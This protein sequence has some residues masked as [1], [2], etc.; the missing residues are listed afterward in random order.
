MASDNPP[1]PNS[2]FFCLW[3]TNSTVHR[4]YDEVRRAPHQRPLEAALI[5][6]EFMLTCDNTM[7]RNN[8]RAHWDGIKAVQ[9][10]FAYSDYCYVFFGSA[11]GEESKETFGGSFRYLDEVVDPAGSSDLYC[12]VDRE[13][14]APASSAEVFHDLLV[15]DEDGT[16]ERLC[17]TGY[18]V[19]QQA[20]SFGAAGRLPEQLTPAEC[21]AAAGAAGAEPGAASTDSQKGWAV[22]LSALMAP[23]TFGTAPAKA[24]A[25]AK[26]SVPPPRNWAH[27]KDW[28]YLFDGDGSDETFA[29]N[30]LEAN[31]DGLE[32]AGFW[33]MPPPVEPANPDYV[34]RFDGECKGQGV[35]DYRVFQGCH[36]S[37]PQHVKSDD[38]PGT[39]REEHI[40]ECAKACSQLD[41]DG[42]LDGLRSTGWTLR[43]F[44]LIPSTGR[45]W[46]TETDALTCD[47]VSKE[48][49][50]HAG[51]DQA[52]TI[53]D[54]GLGYERFDYVSLPVAPHPTCR[55]T[56]E[57]GLAGTATPSRQCIFPF[58][59]DGKL[60]HGCTEYNNNGIAWCGTTSDVDIEPDG[61]GNCDVKN[62]QVGDDDDDHGSG[63]MECPF[64]TTHT[65]AP[66][67]SS[68]T[69]TTSTT[70]TAEPWSGFGSGSGMISDDKHLRKVCKEVSTTVETF[71]EMSLDFKGFKGWDTSGD[72]WFGSSDLEF[73]DDDGE[74]MVGVQFLPIDIPQNARV[75]SAHISFVDDG[76]WGNQ[77][78]AAKIWA[79]HATKPALFDDDVSFDLTREGRDRT[80]GLP[81]G[82]KIWHLETAQNLPTDSAVARSDPT[83]CLYG[84]AS[85]GVG[86]CWANSA[87]NMCP[88]DPHAAHDAVL[89]SGPAGDN[90]R[91]HSKFLELMRTNEFGCFGAGE[92]F[93]LATGPVVAN[94]P[95]F[96]K[97]ESCNS[98]DAP[99]VAIQKEVYLPLA[100]SGL[101]ELDRP[102][103]VGG[104]RYIIV[105]IDAEPTCSSLSGAALIYFNADSDV[106]LSA[107]NDAWQIVAG[108]EAEPA[109]ELT[110]A[111]ACPSGAYYYRFP[112]ETSDS[113][114]ACTVAGWGGE[115]WS[116]SKDECIMDEVKVNANGMVCLRP[117][118]SFACDAAGYL[119]STNCAADVAFLDS[120]RSA[121]LKCVEGSPKDGY[122]YSGYTT[123]SD[124][125]L[126]STSSKEGCTMDASSMERLVGNNITVG[127][128]TSTFNPSLIGEMIMLAHTF[129]LGGT[130]DSGSRPSSDGCNSYVRY[131]NEY[132][133]GC[134]THATLAPTPTPKFTPPPPPTTP[135][136]GS[137]VR[138][139]VALPDWNAADNRPTFFFKR[140][141]GMGKR[142]FLSEKSTTVLTAN[143]CTLEEHHACRVEAVNSRSDDGVPCVFPFTYKGQTYS[144]CTD[145]ENDGVPWCATTNKFA[146]E[147][148][149]G[150]CAE[151]CPIQESKPH[152]TC[153]TSDPI[154]PPHDQRNCPH[155]EAHWETC[156]GDSAYHECTDREAAYNAVMDGNSGDAE[157]MY[158]KYAELMHTHQFGCY[159]IDSEPALAGTQCV[160]PFVYQNVTYNG[161][162]KANKEGVL[163]PFPF[164]VEKAKPAWC[165]TVTNY[166]ENA[167]YD[168]PSW[169]YCD[170]AHYYNK[171]C[172]IKDEPECTYFVEEC[173]DDSGGAP[174]SPYWGYVY[175]P[176]STGK[177]R[178]FV[179][180]SSHEENDDWQNDV[181]TAVSFSSFAECESSRAKHSCRVNGPTDV[182]CNYGKEQGGSENE[183]CPIHNGGWDWHCTCCAALLFD[184]LSFVVNPIIDIF[185]LLLPFFFFFFWLFFC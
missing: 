91:M 168:V 35:E 38:N 25:P 100:K 68:S 49:H 90:E 50:V 108:P 78:L 59:Y 152:Q 53:G 166:D 162:T 177:P 30:W 101:F 110:Y 150:V 179:S 103:F 113:S 96:P 164:T 105:A 69:S 82:K 12:M 57:V 158:A 36:Y 70:S 71:S 56:D 126:D 81:G 141:A 65:T 14:F 154:L 159:S 121:K 109:A 148:H 173:F 75:V 143:V 155:G 125:T 43:G 86:T 142:R 37:E 63:S 16:F 21:A 52:C 175:S 130:E 28:C 26:G 172:S 42:T 120:T 99:F 133:G 178:N 73:F 32:S 119:K 131:V 128:G 169:G 7:T 83:N 24:P 87:F 160:F 66:P 33:C 88:G 181:D 84:D 182:A 171:D 111:R 102:I 34:K 145:V 9:K 97:D 180:T 17:P 184:A 62:Q 170:M 176:Q 185:L 151:D 140:H 72:M 20:P 44:V 156:W 64:D 104:V 116:E 138:H 29:A 5:Y 98:N 27:R 127:C 139:L 13:S 89:A 41:A 153:V 74:Q 46:C 132:I 79:E 61:W 19:R 122:V 144:A 163:K 93:V 47:V 39:T 92:S 149:W 2:F 31:G 114:D 45:C 8:D 107:Y 85:A 115:C 6:M 135:D 4:P 165:A 22:M 183:T 124:G 118:G 60:F 40:I 77:P 161:C 137:I 129:H 134:I 11:E 147:L 1:T 94:W 167:H 23:M 54:N 80:E 51:T 123:N 10:P 136:I 157:A 55:T 58:H 146:K 117:E 95:D 112:E 18:A 15:A 67:V 174:D 48:R 106:K 3:L 76:G